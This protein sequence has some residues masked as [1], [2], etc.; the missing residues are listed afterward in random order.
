VFADVIPS[1]IFEAMAMG[2][3]LLIAAPEGEATRIVEQTGA[4]LAVAPEDPVALADAALQ[5]MDDDTLRT[6]LAAASRTAAARF[7]R[8]T[9][10]DTMMAVL[11]ATA[12]GRGGEVAE[13]AEPAGADEAG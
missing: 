6:R 3:P 11:E 7:S 2:L 12:A 13:C 1:K 10:A 8:R 5:L 9:Q 4:G